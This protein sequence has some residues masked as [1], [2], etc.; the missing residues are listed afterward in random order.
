[1]AAPADFASSGIISGVG[2]ASAKII[3]SFAIVLTHSD[4]S[5]PAL[6]TPINISEPLSASCND[7]LCEELM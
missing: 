5:N 4:V 3:G 2:F 7:P 6:E 1:M